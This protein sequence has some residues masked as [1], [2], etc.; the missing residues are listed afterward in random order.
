VICPI[1]GQ[2]IGY[3]PVSSEKDVDIAVKSAATAFK[4]WSAITVKSRVQILIRFHQLVVKHADELATLIMKEHGK[5]RGEAMGEISKG[6]ETV[7]YAISLP[8]LLQGRI[9]E[10]SRG[11]TCRDSRTPVGVFA[12]IVPF[13]FPFMVPFWFVI[14]LIR[15]LFPSALQL[16]TLVSS[17][18]LKKCR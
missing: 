8:Q 17:S 13:N 5:T 15:G 6:N 4:S 18:L 9:L 7:E 2:V 1:D 3:C 10:V 14:P 12:S 11:V 16:E